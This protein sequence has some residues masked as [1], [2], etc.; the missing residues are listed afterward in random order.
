ASD[1]H[2]VTDE[3]HV[4]NIL[5]QVHHETDGTMMPEVENLT[6]TTTERLRKVWPSRFPTDASAAPYV[7]NPE[8]LAIKVYG[9]RLGNRAG[10]RDGWLYRGQGQIQ[11]T[12]RGHF[13][14][15]GDL[16]GVDLVGNPERALEL[17]ISAEIAVVG[18]ARGLF[19]GKSLGD[20]F[21]ATRDDPAA[22]RAIVNGDVRVNGPRIATL[23]RAFPGR[24]AGR[25]GRP[26]PVP[27]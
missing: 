5:A 24:P 17:E 19:T 2:G 13:Q 26:G 10:T 1:R 27:G 9:D 11:P 18:M 15:F 16:L 3:R 6:Y 12:G 21:S 7:R 22:A 20:Y 14:T 23:H 8:A 25:P 4:A